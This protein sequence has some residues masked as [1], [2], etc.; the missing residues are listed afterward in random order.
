VAC[1]ITGRED[2]FESHTELSKSQEGGTSAPHL[3]HPPVAPI[4]KR[5]RVAAGRRSAR[6]FRSERSERLHGPR[7][8]LHSPRVRLRPGEPRRVPRRPGGTT[9]I[10][11]MRWA[12][13]GRPSPLPLG[14][15]AQDP[16]LSFGHPLPA[17]GLPHLAFGHPLP[18]GEG[19]E[20]AGDGRRAAQRHGFPSDSLPRSPWECRLR[21]SASHECRRQRTRSVPDGIP[22]EDR[23]NE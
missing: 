16:H 20:V 12:W 22:T 4:R 1:C 10:G 17:F 2:A 15:G 7:V 19:G 9:A 14:E 5:N 21:R 23:G 6:R 11:A 3:Y 18:E 8:R 13:S